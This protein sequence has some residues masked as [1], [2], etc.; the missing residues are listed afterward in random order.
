LSRDAAF[1]IAQGQAVQVPKAPTSGLVRLFSEEKGFI[2]IGEILEDGRVKPH[3]LF[4]IA[5]KD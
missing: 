4:F 2:G 5:N 3:R 1:Y